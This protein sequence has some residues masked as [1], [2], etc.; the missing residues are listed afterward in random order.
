VRVVWVTNRKL[1]LRFRINFSNQGDMLG[2]L[3]RL[4]AADHSHGGKHFSITPYSVFH[5]DRPS[6]AKHNILGA[7]EDKLAQLG[8]CLRLMSGEMGDY[9]LMITLPSRAA[10]TRPKLTS[11]ANR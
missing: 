11:D 4:R 9:P 7:E 2:T 8:A 1:T 10:R 6:S 3:R 5:A